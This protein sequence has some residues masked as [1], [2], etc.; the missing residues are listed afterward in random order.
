MQPVLNTVL[1]IAIL[2]FATSLQ[3]LQKFSTGKFEG[4]DKLNSDEH[5]PKQVWP[6]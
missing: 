1:I 4:E 2:Y 5:H 6:T 3:L